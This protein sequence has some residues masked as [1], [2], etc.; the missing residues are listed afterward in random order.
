M[1]VTLVMERLNL[2]VLKPKCEQLL[3]ELS[4]TSAFWVM[5]GSQVSC[6]KNNILGKDSRNAG[7]FR[8]RSEKDH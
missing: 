6:R 5:R 4:S 8:R 7:C 2:L 1:Q 3:K